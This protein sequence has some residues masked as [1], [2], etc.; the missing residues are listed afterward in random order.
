MNSNKAHWHDACEHD[1]PR[2][3]FLG[4][5]EH[6]N[7][8]YDVYVYQDNALDKKP[9]MHVCIRYGNKDSAYISP[10]N[11][12]DFINR[13]QNNDDKL[14]YSKTLVFLKEWKFNSKK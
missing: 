5:F 6:E 2:D 3:R 4:T 13:W 8:K 11:V 7:K 9:D 12:D 14:I 1:R 10:G